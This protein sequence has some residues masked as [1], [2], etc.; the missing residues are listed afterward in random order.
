MQQESA[1]TYLNKPWS[2]CHIFRNLTLSSYCTPS[3][4]VAPKWDSL[5]VAGAG[6]QTKMIL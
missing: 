2:E 3:S 6:H 5:Q 1:K 4:R